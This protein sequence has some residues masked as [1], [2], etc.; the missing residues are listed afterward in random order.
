MYGAQDLE[1]GEEE[2]P[3][4]LREREKAERRERFLGRCAIMTSCKTF[5]VALI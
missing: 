4:T 3:S 5:M 2:E 1:E